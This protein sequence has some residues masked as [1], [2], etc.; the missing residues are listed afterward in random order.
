MITKKNEIECWFIFKTADK[1]E[2]CTYLTKWGEWSSDINDVE[3]M[4][5]TE[6]S[7]RCVEYENGA[8]GSCTVK[9]VM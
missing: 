5:E 1:L 4:S 2:D 7:N 9:I 6:A 8:C 3:L